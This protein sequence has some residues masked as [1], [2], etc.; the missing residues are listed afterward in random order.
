MKKNMQTGF[1]GSFSASDLEHIRGAV[2]EAERSTSGE[3]VPCIVAQSDAYE[4]AIWRS[5][6]IVPISLMGMIMLL[7]MGTDVWL[8][9]SLMES[10][11]MTILITVLAMGA[12]SFSP[13]LR[14]ILAGKTLRERRVMQGARETFLREEVFR[15]RQRTGILLYVSLLEHEVVVIGDTGINARVHPH[16]WDEV[17]NLVVSGMKSGNPADGIIKAIFRCRDLLRKHGFEQRRDDTN[18]LPDNARGYEE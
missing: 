9:V 6:T 16:E 13:T 5:G 12:V 2:E 1:P 7:R 10:L 18:E 17:T 4:E 14:R 15:T 3:I 8:P 11:L